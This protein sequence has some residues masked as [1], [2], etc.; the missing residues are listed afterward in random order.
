MKKR[1]HHYVWRHYLESWADIDDGQIYCLRNGNIFKTNPINVANKRDFYRLKEFS[2]EDVNH[3][4]EIIKRSPAFLQQEYHNL[5]LLFDVLY[6]FKRNAELNGKIDSEM[7]MVLDTQINNLEEEIHTRVENSGMKYVHMLLNRDLSFVR[8]KLD[9][10]LFIKFLCM[11][12]MRTEKRRVNAIK[13]TTWQNIIDTGKIWNILSHIFAT[14]MAWSLLNDIRDFTFLVMDNKS[15]NPFL[16]GDQPVINTH[17]TETALME[18]VYDVEFYYP[19]SPERAMVLT[20]TPEKHSQVNAVAVDMYNR[21]IVLGSHEQI[22][23]CTRE[24]LDRL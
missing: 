10:I 1:R 7:E 23:S 19:L 21:H 5:I 4:K 9:T 24:S 17:G 12:Y 14:N 13:A 3:I 22:F 15:G 16:T 8:S 20:K 6:Q 18:H 11:Q 2:V